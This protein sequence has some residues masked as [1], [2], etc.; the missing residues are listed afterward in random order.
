MEAFRHS[1]GMPP[2][3]EQFLIAAIGASLLPGLW[4]LI[5]GLWL[6]IRWSGNRRNFGRLLIGLAVFATLAAIFY[7][8]ED[9][10]GKRA[11]EKCK[12]ELEAKGIVLDYDKYIPPPVPDDQNFF[13][14]NTNIML[15]FHKVQTEAEYEAATNCQWL[16]IDY[17]THLFPVFDSAKTKPLIVAEITVEP[18][19][20][21]VSSAGGSHWL[22]AKLNAVD[23]REQV[24]GLIRTTIGRGISGAAGFQFSERQLSNLA[25]AQIVLQSDTTPSVADLQNLIPEDLA[26][27]VGHLRIEAVGGQKSFRVLLTGV[28]I[29]AAAD[30]LK[31]SD[32]FIPA[33]DEVREALKRPYA[34]IPGD[35]SQ[36]YFQPIP[37]FITLR[38]LAQLL[39]QR[40]QCE[41]LLGQPDQ[42]LRDLTL[43]H[44]LCRILEHRPTGQPTTLVEAMINVAITGLYAGT[45]ADGFRFH[46]WQEP[47]MAALQEQLKE[48]DLPPQVANAFRW[49]MVASTHTFETTPAAKIAGL[50]T[51]ADTLARDKETGIWTKL[52]NPMYL[53]LKVA[54]RGW[55]HQNM[56]NTAQTESKVMADFDLGDDIISPRVFDETARS[57]EKQLRRRSPFNIWAAYVIP[58]TA[59]ATQTT[60][61]TQTLANEAQIVCALER[62]RLVHGEYPETLDALTPQFIHKLP[63]DIIG[64]PPAQGSGSASQPLHYRRTAG[65]QFILYSVGW[66]E[67]DDGGQD[68][69]ATSPNDFTQGDWVW[70]N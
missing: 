64:G 54:P 55:I 21:A 62:Y 41:F 26:T 19:T 53:F 46:V 14:A 49:G 13:M 63:H 23:A 43:V 35:Y 56:V 45:I 8:E 42:A 44:D 40:A 67:T 15:R 9:W 11:W 4:L 3:W 70:K 29:T 10:R 28:R 61:H 69:S 27:N 58:N 38:A 59:K 33:L 12:A 68:V 7:L 16:R 17:S 65:G 5:L 36:T 37:N 6:F 47:Q 24:Q 34:I 66:N 20:T 51:S 22:V 25:P 60:A 18:F 30:Y 50:L 57:L 32:Q 52:K 2:Y 48:I 39:A 1:T 31:W